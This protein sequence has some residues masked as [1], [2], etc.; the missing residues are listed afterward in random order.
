MVKASRRDL[1]TGDPRRGPGVS[2]LC[3]PSRAPSGPNRS[4]ETIRSGAGRVVRIRRRHRARQKFRGGKEIS[5][6][7]EPQICL[8]CNSTT[9]RA[10]TTSSSRSSTTPSPLPSQRSGSM[11]FGGTCVRSPNRG[12]GTGRRA[13][14]RFHPNDV[15]DEHPTAWTGPG[16][17]PPPMGGGAGRGVGERGLRFQEPGHDE[18]SLFPRVQPPRVAPAPSCVVGHTNNTGTGRNREHWEEAK[19]SAALPRKSQDAM[20]PAKPVHATMYHA[21]G[22][23]NDK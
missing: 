8:Y 1:S 5:V 7:L 16:I 21:P 19:A 3:S 23:A 10:P 14:E 20:Q 9:P 4:Q 11:G 22:D 15:R 18:P 6:A 17:R 2:S 13:R 12:P